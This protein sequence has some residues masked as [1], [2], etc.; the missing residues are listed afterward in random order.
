M[1]TRDIGPVQL[2]GK[3]FDIS[4]SYY[5]SIYCK[6]GCYIVGIEQFRVTAKRKSRYDL[7]FAPVPLSYTEPRRYDK[8]QVACFETAKYALQEEVDDTLLP[9]LQRYMRDD[10]AH[11][12]W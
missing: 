6:E 2:Y 7:S 1:K 3:T 11:P 9:L 4:Y 5:L 12:D 8:Y 10:N